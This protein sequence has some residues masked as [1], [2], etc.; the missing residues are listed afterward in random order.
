MPL[1]EKKL[2]T[3][4]PASKEL[5]SKKVLGVLK[6]FHIT[7]KSS[8]GVALNKYVFIVSPSANKTQVKNDVEARYKVNIES[9]R[10]INLPDKER[11]KGRQIGWRAGLRKATVTVRQGQKIEIE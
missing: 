7:E 2:K 1:F 5:S 4:K 10:I 11:R 9:V 3:E 8:A 6:S